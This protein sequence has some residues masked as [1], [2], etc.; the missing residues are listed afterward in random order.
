MPKS[1][2]LL[3]MGENIMY[4]YCIDLLLIIIMYVSPIVNFQS[5]TKTEK[6]YWEKMHIRVSMHS[7][8]NKKV[9]VTRL[10]IS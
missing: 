5:Q 1:I 9:F 10:N 4:I 2:V 8:Y 7:E 3:K 6:N